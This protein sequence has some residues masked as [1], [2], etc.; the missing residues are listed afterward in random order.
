VKSV[1]SAVGS[2]TSGDGPDASTMA[3]RASA[4]LTVTLDSL[5]TRKRKQSEI[6]NDIRAALSSIPGA[7]IQVGVGADGT[8]LG[9]CLAGD[10]AAQLETT[11]ALLEA[12]LRTLKGTGAVVSSAALEAPEIRIIPDP[13]RAAAHGV[14]SE[15]IAGVARVATN[16]DYA[17][18]LAKLNLPARQVPI[19]VSLAGTVRED[20]D[21]LA[22]LRVPAAGGGAV[23]LGSVARIEAGGGPAMI[24]R[25]DRSRNIIVSVELNGRALGEV[26][27]EALRLPVMQNLPE[28]VSLVE[29]GDTQNMSEMFESFGAAM[30]VGL[31]CVYAVLVLL[32]H[33]FLQPVTILAAIP[34]A[35]GGALL[36]LVVTG[37]SFSMAAILGL[38]MLMGI[39]T[40]NSILLVEYIIMSRG[41]GMGRAGAVTEACRKRVRPILMT[42]FA[43]TGGMLPCVLGLSGG[44]SSFRFPMT[45]VVVGGLATSTLLSLVVIPVAY[46]LLDDITVFITRLAKREK[47]PVANIPEAPGPQGTI[48]AAF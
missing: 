28:T 19:R 27:R 21:A 15:A 2:A 14:T 47:N 16:G 23:T 43:M 30:L 8:S 38:L 39:V 40:K 36:P 37:S 24:S 41:K 10:D 17:V 46:T 4:T 32:F 12:Q 11:A 25:L 29:Q 33:D 22:Q 20:V 45:V 26:M 18:R 13:A 44:D 48:P 9:I 6:E 7:R 34:L 3:D 5:A 42:T 35:L 1:F 31:L